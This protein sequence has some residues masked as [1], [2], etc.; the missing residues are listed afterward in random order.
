MSIKKLSFML[1]SAISL[2]AL[3]N[4]CGSS[5][6][7]GSPGGVARVSDEGV[8]IVCHSTTIDHTSGTNIVTDY[9]TAAHKVDAVGCEGC[10]GG[11]SQHN[12]V[13]PFP[14]PNPL[15][16]DRCITC[17]TAN[18]LADTSEDLAPLF[19]R[20]KDTTGATGVGF[21]D[22]KCAH[23]H[24]ASGVGSVHGAQVPTTQDC[25][26]CHDVPT[27]QH[28][29]G[30]V[31]DNNGVRAITTEFAK[32]SHHVTGVTLNDAHCTAC[33]LEG[34]VVNGAVV[35][36]ETKHMADAKIHLRNADTDADFAWNPAAPVQATSP[37]W[38]TSA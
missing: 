38:I 22:N 32:W 26:Q 16:A 15:T 18:G 2:T 6:K 21:T 11:G 8:C 31:G 33:H 37:V 7:E 5:S 12:G 13:G 4:G 19:A 17:H 23:C 34:T 36:D 25:I 9:G 35:I 3:L 1:L 30:R 14:Y 24:T 28:G 20:A 29:S 10:H 27:P